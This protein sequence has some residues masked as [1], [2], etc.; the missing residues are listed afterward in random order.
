MERVY[1]EVVAK[2]SPEGA[3]EPLFIVWE[4]GR[5]FSVD[6]VLDKRR[7]TS[8]KVGGIGMRY[9]CVISGKTR[10]LF[11]EDDRWFVEAK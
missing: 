5:R 2:H 9:T 11:Y 6:R 1:V 4:D 10:Y 7:R 3:V 8:L